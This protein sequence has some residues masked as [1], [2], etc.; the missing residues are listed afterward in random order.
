[1]PAP[2]D[3]E[4]EALSYLDSVYRV[5]RWLCGDPTEASDLTQ[6]TY[7]RAFRA[8]E[9]FIRTNMR[10]WLLTI[11]R[12][13]FLN[14][15]R[16]HDIA[17]ETPLEEADAQIAQAIPGLPDGVLRHD[18]EAALAKLPIEL[19]LPLLLADV[20]EMS[21]AEI[22]EALGWPVGTVKSRLWRARGQLA[23]LLREYGERRG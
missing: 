16:R 18:V 8:R 5:A 7:E 3:F 13:H 19:R 17:G 21:M 23:S 11:L 9:R 14:T 10:A 15:R 12:R 20:E 6:D 22:A 2:W 4:T 1:M